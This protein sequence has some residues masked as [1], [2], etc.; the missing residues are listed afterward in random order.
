M[1]RRQLLGPQ[2]YFLRG[3]WR[4][5][6]R[7]GIDVTAELA[8]LDRLIERGHVRRAEVVPL[9]E[10]VS[11]KVTSAIVFAEALTAVAASLDPGRADNG[12]IH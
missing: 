5:F 9:V 1:G 6:A 11:A 2:L 7:Q 10:R 8:A 12:P 3:L 4:G